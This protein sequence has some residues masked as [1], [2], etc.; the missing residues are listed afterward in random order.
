MLAA[1]GERGHERVLCAGGGRT[2]SGLLGEQLVDEL[3]LTVTPWLLDGR[4][5]VPMLSRGRVFT[6]M[7]LVA[8]QTVENEVFLRYRT[9]GRPPWPRLEEAAS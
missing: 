1:L 9:V 8:S 4:S 5:T 6:G 2:V 3:F 7:Q